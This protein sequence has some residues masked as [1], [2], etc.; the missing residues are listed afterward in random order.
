[1]SAFGS[2]LSPGVEARMIVEPQIM[3]STG[4]FERIPALKRNCVFGNERNLSF[5]RTYTQRN[6]A[7]ECEAQFTLDACKCV[8][9]Y[10][11]SKSLSQI[12]FK[13]GIIEFPFINALILATF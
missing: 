4:Q 3:T 10:M 11:P 5:Y 6:C 8:L 13:L 7:Q 1:M 12:N 9:Y 2:L